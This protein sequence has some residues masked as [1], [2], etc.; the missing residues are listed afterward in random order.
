[1]PR[2]NSGGT[3]NPPP[4]AGTVGISFEQLESFENTKLLKASVQNARLQKNAQLLLSL[5]S[6]HLSGF[7]NQK[8]F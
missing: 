7:G 2:S 1:M 8:F 4:C 5:S 3:N 6:C